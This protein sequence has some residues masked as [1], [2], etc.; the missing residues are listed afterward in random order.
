MPVNVN[1]SAGHDGDA[2]RLLMN[3]LKGGSDYIAG[4][5]SLM[6]QSFDTADMRRRSKSGEIHGI[7]A[8]KTGIDQH[9]RGRHS[10]CLPFDT[11][12]GDGQ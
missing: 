2:W 7:I 12:S 1:P 3:C 10:S 5:W 4:W 8:G 6:R 9:V 11:R